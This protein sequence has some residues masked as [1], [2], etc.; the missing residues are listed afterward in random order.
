MKKPT[1][2]PSIKKGKLVGVWHPLQPLLE[3][4]AVSLEDIALSLQPNKVEPEKPKTKKLIVKSFPEF[5]GKPRKKLYEFL[6]KNHPNEMAGE[7][8]M[9][10]IFKHP[11]NYP[12]L[13]DGNWYYFF[14]VAFCSTDGSWNVTCVRWRGSEFGRHGYWLDN[15]WSGDDRVVLLD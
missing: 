8:A 15:D 11:E 6:K 1:K 4:I 5:V 3:R 14:A 7:D 2:K 12:H 9:L 10:D 13:K